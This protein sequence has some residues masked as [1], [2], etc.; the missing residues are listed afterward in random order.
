MNKKVLSIGG[1]TVDIFINYQDAETLKI[2]NKKGHRSFILFEY[3]AK[4]EVTD[5]NYYTGGGGTNSSVSFSR[6]DYDANVVCKIGGD[7]YG[8]KVLQKL[9]SES[10]KTDHVVI[11]ENER[12][13]TSFILP[14]LENDRTIFAF[15][16]VT[17]KLTESEIPEK[18]LSNYNL[19]YIT[20][21]SGHSSQV[22]KP[23]VKKA[24]KQNLFIA[25]NPGISQ[26]KA[27][28]TSLADS[29]QYIDIFI[30]NS[31]EAKQFMHSLLEK[32]YI[33]SSPKE[34]TKACVTA[35]EGK[36]PELFQSFTC[37]EDIHFNLGHYF[38]D[39]LQRG[40]KI[41][42]V[43]NGS[44]GVY[45]ADKNGMYFCPSPEVPVKNTLGAGDAFGSC[46]TACVFGGDNIEDALKKAVL[47]ACSAVGYEDAKTG[48]L[49]KEKLEE[50]FKI[51][52][53]KVKKVNL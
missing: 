16:G 22:F 36:G 44:E 32:D 19:L 29:L 50:A 52:N 49:T 47:N 27:G 31:C 20:S 25:T 15:R 48:L 14:S 23:L 1:A 10:V 38:K 33:K 34:K 35:Q 37:Y 4:L 6:L 39:I 24:K 9:K 18:K 7:N 51:S 41:V 11:T 26:L 21:L 30:V 53:V 13:G 45:A 42:V 12:T 17:T 28:A 40:P 3:G 46:F 2:S 5:L 8:E 43:T